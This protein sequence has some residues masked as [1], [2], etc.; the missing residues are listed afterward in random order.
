MA[1]EIGAVANFRVIEKL[2]PKFMLLNGHETLN[3]GLI[4]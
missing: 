3:K 2:G 4:G 1:L